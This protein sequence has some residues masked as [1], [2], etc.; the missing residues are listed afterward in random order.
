MALPQVIATGNV[1]YE[2]EFKVLESGLSLCKI[3]IACNER[4]KVND[5]W[6]DGDT[7][8]IDVVLWRNLADAAGE[9]RKGQSVTVIGK[10]RISSYL[11]KNGNKGTSIDI[12]A[13][14]IALTLKP[15][16]SSVEAPF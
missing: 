10:L 15:V 14:D 5:E 8:Y 4:K 2:P 13:T 11:D 7:T 3:R 1:V 6:V 12:E 16:R 9:L